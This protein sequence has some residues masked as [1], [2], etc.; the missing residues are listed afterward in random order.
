[1]SAADVAEIRATLANIESI[2]AKD[3]GGG[4]RAVV[5]STRATLTNVENI[6]ARDN[7]GGIRGVVNSILAK[8][9][10]LNTSAPLGDIDDADL[11]AIATAVSDEADR[12]NK[13]RANT[14]VK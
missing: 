2:L 8:V 7:G 6:I 10:G 14:E 1:M 11:K 13:A 4:I 5:G 9:N 12:R 3:N